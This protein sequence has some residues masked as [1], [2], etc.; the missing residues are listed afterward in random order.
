MRT[1]AAFMPA[2]ILPDAS[3]RLELHFGRGVG[4]GGPNFR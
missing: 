2:R 4:V 1:A 3:T